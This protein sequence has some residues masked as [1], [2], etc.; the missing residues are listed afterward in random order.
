MPETLP[1]RRCVA[2]E[3]PFHAQDQCLDERQFSDDFT[4]MA[5]RAK[6]QERSTSGHEARSHRLDPHVAAIAGDVVPGP[7]FDMKDVRVERSAIMRNKDAIAVGSWIP[8][9]LVNRTRRS[10]VH[11]IAWHEC[12]KRIPHR[13][14]AGYPIERLKF[15]RVRGHATT[16]RRGG[17]LHPLPRVFLRQAGGF[18]CNAAEVTS[19]YFSPAPVLNNTTCC[20]E[21]RTPVASR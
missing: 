5:R 7:R 20:E 12:R 18:S 19:V 6:D 14:A 8:S 3:Q 15:V 9:R 10:E 4:F 16:P 2:T 17:A 1:S 13:Y 11:G 21:L